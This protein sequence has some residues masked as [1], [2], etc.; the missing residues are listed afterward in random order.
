VSFQSITEEQ[1]HN[2]RFSVVDRAEGV[3]L[4]VY[5]VTKS[6][7]DGLLDS[8]DWDSLVRQISILPQNL[9]GLYAETFERRNGDDQHL[10]QAETALYFNLMLEH[11]Y[12]LSLFKAGLMSRPSLL[13]SLLSGGSEVQERYVFQQCQIVRQRIL[14]KCVGLLEVPELQ[15]FDDGRSVPIVCVYFMHRSARDFLKDTQDGQ[16]ILSHDLRSSAE[17][18]Y[19]YWFA[20]MLER[21]HSKH[22]N[23]YESS[24]QLDL[25][26]IFFTISHSLTGFG[27]RQNCNLQWYQPSLELPS[28][29]LVTSFLQRRFPTTMIHNAMLEFAAL[30]GS[31]QF[32]AR[33]MQS[34]TPA[35]SSNV[36]ISKSKI[37]SYATDTPLYFGCSPMLLATLDQSLV[38]QASLIN[39]LL[40]EGADPNFLPPEINHSPVLW[41]IYQTPFIKFLQQ[42]RSCLLG[43]GAR[44]TLSMNTWMNLAYAFLEHGADPE[45]RSLQQTKRSQL[46]HF[47]FLGN[48]PQDKWMQKTD[49]RL[50]VLMETSACQIFRGV[51]KELEEWIESCD[52]P[53]PRKRRI[54]L[55]LDEGNSEPEQ[56]VLLV[57]KTADKREYFWV[58]SR[59]PNE[60]VVKDFWAESLP[61]SIVQVDPVEVSRMLMNMGYLPQDAANPDANNFEFRSMRMG[62][63]DD[64][65]IHLDLPGT[66]W[67]YKP[68]Y[69]N[70]VEA[71][72]RLESSTMGNPSPSGIPTQ[73]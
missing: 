64:T 45:L 2:L 6:I 11:D 52:Q 68:E 24:K 61:F 34:L 73:A 23:E 14:A 44:S 5:L 27:L 70:F 22:L 53:E 41:G 56:V 16:R 58:A 29:D 49:L 30:T 66:D 38:K 8:D 37:L 59:F 65:Y 15:T 47:G 7:R 67:S 26:A 46:P 21:M 17:R 3:F 10:Y 18:D 4:W 54:R 39:W 20:S 25:A 51:E 28:L 40:E 19:A 71:V 55:L 36:Q 63:E 72:K 42:L 62:P 31:K 32:L 43:V 48:Y 69:D 57:R 60:P 12:D 13:R 35:C 1:L 50:A 9:S 33:F